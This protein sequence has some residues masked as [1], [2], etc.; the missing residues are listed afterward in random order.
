MTSNCSRTPLA[1]TLLHYMSRRPSRGYV[2]NN[3]TERQALCEMTR[4][5]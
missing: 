2:A 5:R 3:L 1:A 4:R